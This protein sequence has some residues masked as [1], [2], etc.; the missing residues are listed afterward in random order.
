MHQPRI[1][2]IIYS[3]YGHI[4]TMAEAVKKGV[5]SKG[6]KADIYQVPET[7]PEEVLGKMHAPPKREFPIATPKTLNNYDAFLFGIPTRYGNMPAQMKAF[8]DSTG[9]LWAQG[10]LAGKY[11]GMFVS[12]SGPGGGQEM[13][14]LTFLSTLVHHGMIYVPLGYATGL[15]GMV[16]MTEVHGSSPWGAGTFAGSDGRRQP[17]ELELNIAKVQGSA[18]YDIVSRVNFAKPSTTVNV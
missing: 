4:A 15:A 17:S 18:F 2:I 1:A 16:S 9:Q 8:I 13:T 5:D 3:M 6:G 10:S 12:T 7:L 14:P 11:A